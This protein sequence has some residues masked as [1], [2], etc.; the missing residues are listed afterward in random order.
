MGNEKEK[1]KFDKES[2]ERA[3]LSGADAEIVQRY[4]SAVKEHITAYSGI[5][6]ETGKILKKSLKSISQSKV[7]PKHADQNIKQQAGFSAEVLD[8]ANKNTENIINKNPTRKVRADDVGK[9]NDEYFD[10]FMLDKNGEI[11][12]GS[13]TQ[14]K[15]VGKNPKE[16][17]DKL[18]SKD[19]DKYFD[20]DVP[21]ELPHDYYDS[22]KE[23]SEQ[24][25]K[26][27]EA[28]Y[29]KQVAEGKTEQAEYTKQKLSRAKKINKN[30]RKSSVSNKQAVSARLH[31][32][33]ETAKNIGKISNKAGLE[34]AK[35]GVAVGGVSS[36]VQNVV[37]IA[38]GEEETEEAIKNVVKDTGK[39]AVFS[40]GSGFAGSAVKGVMQNAGS[41]YVRALSKTNLAGTIVNVAVTSTKVVSKYVRGEISGTECVENLGQEGVGLIASSMGAA[42]GQALIPIPVV[43]AMVGSMVGYAISSASY[44]VLTSSLK[45]AKLSEEERQRVEQ[46]CEEQIEL[47]RK[48]RAELEELIT[49]YLSEK[50]TVFQDA[51]DGI[52]SALEIGD[53]DGFITG[54]NM[55]TQNLGKEVQFEN[56]EEFNEIMSSSDSFKL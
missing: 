17:Y 30:I 7:N 27:L 35:I 38:K 56:M 43:G 22:V 54:T 13:G 11:I 52:K 41:T 18:N 48:Y 5:D 29:K 34:A 12:K 42:V 40:Y 50:A 4:G 28:A 14:M 44:G 55:I 10:T 49:E 25:I 23:I 24:E 1:I 39:A 36:I 3:T 9:V 26:K 53:I 46:E 6:N 19:Y 45:E 2:L 32:K 33:L 20:N 51:F 15:F 37:A 31:P 8:V 47:I 16:A 21:V